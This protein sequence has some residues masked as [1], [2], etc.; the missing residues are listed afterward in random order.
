MK[1]AAKA[2]F[3]VRRIKKVRAWDFELDPSSPHAC[4]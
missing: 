1:K 3:F 4:G 2:A